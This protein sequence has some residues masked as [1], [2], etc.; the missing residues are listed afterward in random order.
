MGNILYVIGG[1]LVLI[2]LIGF[3]MRIA[4][5]LIHL[6]LVIA[7]IVFVFRFLSGRR[8]I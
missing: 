6:V 3:L 4:A 2:W 5:G 7:V 8:N 1:L